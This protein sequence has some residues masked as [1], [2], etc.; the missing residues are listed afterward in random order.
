M[1]GNLAG[2][3]DIFVLW[4][5]CQ[6]RLA[7]KERLCRFVLISNDCCC[8]CSKVETQ[9][10]LL[11]SCA[12]IQLIWLE[13]PQWLQVVHTPGVWDMELQWILK[14]C[15]GKEWRARLLKLAFSETVL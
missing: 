4:L 9:Q 15:G 12:T 2:P 1:Y 13:E 7:T 6:G 3:R 10:H 14:K 8:F 11:F 5:A